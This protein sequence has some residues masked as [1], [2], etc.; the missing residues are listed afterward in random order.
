MALGIDATNVYIAKMLG[1]W[2]GILHK[3]DLEIDHP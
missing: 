3:S 2:D 1:R